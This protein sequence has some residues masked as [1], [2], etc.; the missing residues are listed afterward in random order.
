MY[1]KLYQDLPAIREHQRLSMTFRA[2]N[3]TPY[4]DTGIRATT[5]VHGVYPELLSWYSMTLSTTFV[6]P[7]SVGLS[8]C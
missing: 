2:L 6:S 8:K 1:K 3:D 5:L 7:C 4:S